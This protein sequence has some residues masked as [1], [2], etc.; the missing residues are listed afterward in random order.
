MYRKIEKRKTLFLF[1]FILYYRAQIVLHK[2]KDPTQ[3]V[4]GKI[5][6]CITA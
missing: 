3:E 5:L 2:R 6:F 1:Y 4:S